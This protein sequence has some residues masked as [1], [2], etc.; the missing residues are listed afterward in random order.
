[1]EFWIGCYGGEWFAVVAN[2]SSPLISSLAA[3]G[4][5]AG[6]EV[7][8][9]PTAIAAI[10]QA[11]AQIS[12]TAAVWA[13]DGRE[14]V[15]SVEAALDALRMALAVE[16]GARFPR[17][18]PAPRPVIDFEEEEDKPDWYPPRLTAFSADWD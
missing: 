13:G 12:M 10:G 14:A 9:L 4:L 6:W 2:Q 11:M 1:V 16:V 15:P 5:K 18:E 8:G 17:P 7:V 3:D